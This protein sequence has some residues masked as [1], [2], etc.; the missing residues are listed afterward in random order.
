MGSLNF[1]EFK[2]E[3]KLQI[4]QRDDL[5][6]VSG[7]DYIGEWV[8]R[9]YID[10]TT[11]DRFWELRFPAD[12]YFPELEV[13]DASKS[14]SDGVAYVD[15][16]AKTL[17][18]RWVWDSTNDYKLTRFESWIKYIEKT[19]RATAASEG[20]PTKYIR[21]AGG[22]TDRIYLYPTPDTAY[23]LEIGRRKIP[24]ELTGTDV[25]AI[26]EIWDE[27]ILKLAVIQT[28]MRLKE[29]EKARIEKAEW[30]DMVRS[31]VDVYSQEYRDAKKAKIIPDITYL[32]FRY[33]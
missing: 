2:A 10:F 30:I 25:T 28:L 7:V 18:V 14:T 22:G 17:L 31:K 20:K 16:P 29:Y 24:A 8:N 1:S 33:R 21:V 27:P 13:I 4:Y 12:F 26:N 23:S 15:T 11:R 5:D 19:G 9:A 6:S 3:L 32:D